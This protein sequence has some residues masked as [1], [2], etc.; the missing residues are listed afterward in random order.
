MVFNDCYTCKMYCFDW[1]KTKAWV[2]WVCCLWMEIFLIIHNWM[3]LLRGWMPGRS[4]YHILC[5]IDMLLWGVGI[6]VFSSDK[7]FVTVLECIGW[8]Y[9]MALVC[10]RTTVFYN[11][12]FYTTK[13]FYFSGIKINEAE[14]GIVYF[15]KL[16]VWTFEFLISSNQA[17]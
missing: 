11:W 7:I 4:N 9:L 12:Y 8:W 1:C 3:N 13:T 6:Q 15:F 10:H 14:D 5:S 2:L 16:V 17:S